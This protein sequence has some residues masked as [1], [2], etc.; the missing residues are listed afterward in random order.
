DRPGRHT[1]DADTAGC[2]V[3]GERSRERQHGTLRRGVVDERVASPERRDR[4]RVDD[5]GSAFEVGHG[6]PGEVEHREHVGPERTL[7][8]LV[9]EVLEPVDDVLLGGVVDEDVEAAE[10]FD[11]L[12]DR[13]VA[14]RGRADVACDEER[15]PAFRLHLSSRTLRVIVLVEVDD[16]DVGALLREVHRDCAANTAVSATDQ[17]YLAAQLA[18]RPVRF[19]LVTRRRFEFT[20]DTRLPVLMLGWSLLL[21]VWHASRSHPAHARGVDDGNR[22]SILRTRTVG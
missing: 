2:K 19:A 21:L 16:G 12:R 6:G 4:R 7:E 13:V 1:V 18:G 22:D 3:A 9:A 17:G 14:D 15:V 5:A 8:L 20:F 11:G 10:R